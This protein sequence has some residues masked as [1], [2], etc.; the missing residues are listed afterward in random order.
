MSPPPPPPPPLGSQ[1]IL[2]TITGNPYSC[3]LVWHWCGCPKGW[4]S[5]VVEASCPGPSDSATN[6]GGGICSPVPRS[7]EAKKMFRAPLAGNSVVPHCPPC[8]C[9]LGG[10]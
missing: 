1:A 8:W 7:K 6:G 4:W 9:G 2:E 3:Q 10:T 5:P